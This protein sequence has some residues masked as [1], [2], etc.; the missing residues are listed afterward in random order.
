[1][2]TLIHQCRASRHHIED[3]QRFVVSV[4]A[5]DSLLEHQDFIRFILPAT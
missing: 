5:Y 1:M 4:V 2:N 3:K